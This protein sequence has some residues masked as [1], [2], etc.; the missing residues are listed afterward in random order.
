M[1]NKMQRNEMKCAIKHTFWV[2]T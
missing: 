2:A 1:K